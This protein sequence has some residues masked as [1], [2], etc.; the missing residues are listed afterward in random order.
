MCIQEY[1][2]ILK[3]QYF[4]DFSIIGRIIFENHDIFNTVFQFSVFSHLNR[5]G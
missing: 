2:S 5:T 4:S 1:V 3:K